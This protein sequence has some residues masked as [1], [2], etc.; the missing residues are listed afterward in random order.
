MEMSM[1]AQ[2]EM[3]SIARS[4]LLAQFCR[5]WKIASLALFGSVLRADFGPN[6]DVDVL[7][8]FE[9]NVRWTLFDLVTMEDELARLFGRPVDLVERQS[10]EQS[11][12]YIRRRNILGQSQVIYDSR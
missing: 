9:A 2:A 3:I 10:V 4:E 12:N 11:D 5:H 8:T 7:V 1:N 6:S